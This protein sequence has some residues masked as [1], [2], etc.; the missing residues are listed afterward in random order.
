MHKRTVFCVLGDRKRL[1]RTGALSFRSTNF[2]SSATA[3]S[4]AAKIHLSATYL[5]VPW[6]FVSNFDVLHKLSQRPSQERHRLL[7]QPQQLHQDP[8]DSSDWLDFL[9]VCQL[10]LGATSA[11]SLLLADPDRIWMLTAG[12]KRSVV[13][14]VKPALETRGRGRLTTRCW[15]KQFAEHH[16]PRIAPTSI[17]CVATVR[18][19]RRCP[20]IFVRLS[21]AQIRCRPA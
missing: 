3:S 8:P 15:S 14:L 5:S 1:W 2:D 21:S 6:V 16:I 17:C 11:P 13:E 20:H 10:A 19:A 7:C 4:L 18:V 9:S 12:V